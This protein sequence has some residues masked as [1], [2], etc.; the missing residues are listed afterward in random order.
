MVMNQVN[1]GKRLNQTYKVTKSN[2]LI[3]STYKLSLQENRIIATLISMIEPH[4][5]HF[6]IY[7]FN[8]KEFAEMIGVKGKIYSYI[9]EIVTGLQEKTVEIPTE[10]STLVLNWLSSAEYF[11]KEGY[12]ELEISSK[13]KPYLLELKQRFTSYQLR[14]ILRLRSFYSARIYELLKQYEF[15]KHKTRTVDIQTLREW[16]GFINEYENKYSMYGHFKDRVLNL[17]TNPCLS[18][19]NTL[20]KKK[21]IYLHTKISVRL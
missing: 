13:L 4:D 1:E 7:K 15:V 16:L 6:Q 5:A 2:D 21:D 3:E 19:Y 18:K 11:E 8:V 20:L 17:L 10:N 9:K 14:Y 12:I